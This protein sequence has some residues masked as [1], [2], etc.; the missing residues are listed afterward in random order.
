[1]SQSDILIILEKSSIPLSSREIA[2]LLEDNHVK[3]CRMLKIME[4]Y[5]EVESIDLNRMLAYK[6]YNSKRRLKLFYVKK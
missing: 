3:V 1:M 5:K 4:R 2:D 6:F